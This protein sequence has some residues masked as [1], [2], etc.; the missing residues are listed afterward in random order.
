MTAAVVKCFRWVIPSLFFSL[1][2]QPAPDFKV[3][4]NL[5][6]VPCI[7]SEP[8]GAPVKGLQAAD[9]FIR[10]N[11][12]RQEV[13]YL[14]QE[15][16]L[17]LTVVIVAELRGE[18]RDLKI[19]QQVAARF[20]EHLISPNDRA[21]IVT[22]L[23]QPWLVTDLT[24]SLDELRA[25][26]EFPNRPGRILGRACSG[27]HP[28]TWSSREAP[29][30]NNPIWN[31]VFFSAEL[32]LRRQIGRKALLLLSDGLD[33]GSDYSLDDAI[34]AC[35]RADAPVYAVRY[36]SNT[37]HEL[38]G[39]DWVMQGKRDLTRIARQTGGAVFEGKW[40]TMQDVFERI[41]SDLRNQ[42]VLGYTP[43]HSGRD[44]KEHKIKIEVTRPG[45]IVRAQE[46][47]YE[48]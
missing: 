41:E 12:V 15:S 8:N 6:R 3:D 16:D 28:G 45:L 18:L 34:A 30:G 4:V 21:A 19:H 37:W 20:L 17:P 10:D 40:D 26:A 13:K 35:Q 42:Y 27:V 47:R 11:G 9:F 33:T 23:I 14:W 24:N 44:R 31:A 39:P 1:F 7:V 32:G 43:P 38:A 46:R 36:I 2:A 25:G 5:V 29:C 48:Q 22:V